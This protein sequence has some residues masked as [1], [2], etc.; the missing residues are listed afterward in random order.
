MIQPLWGAILLCAAVGAP[1]RVPALT[2]LFVELNEATG[3]AWAAAIGAT[4]SDN[5]AAAA[6]PL[7]LIYA[8][9]NT[10]GP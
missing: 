7:R 10:A 4:A 5:T 8:S 6:I 3:A 2:A 1:E 9:L